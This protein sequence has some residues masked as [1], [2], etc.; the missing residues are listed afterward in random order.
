[1][2]V[3][4]V[5]LAG[6]ELVSTSTMPLK[7]VPN[8]DQAVPLLVRAAQLR[9]EMLH[10]QDGVADLYGQVLA[11]DPDNAEAMRF[12]ASYLFKQGDLAGA[13]TVWR[14]LETSEA[15]RDLEDFDVRMEVSLYF[16]RFA[17]A[18][19]QLGESEAALTHYRRALEL[20]PSHLPSLQLTGGQ[21][22]MVR[23]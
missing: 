5:G 6:L 15:N 16:Y 9:L 3:D 8:P 14:T 7:P 17:E 19:R 22:D 11:R 2:R 4:T 23:I 1:M 10:D 13:V 18:E 12:R 21:G 20:N